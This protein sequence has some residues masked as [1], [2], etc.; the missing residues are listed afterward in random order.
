LEQQKRRE[1]KYNNNTQS[2]PTTAARKKQASGSNNNNNGERKKQKPCN[3]VNKCFK[4]YFLWERPVSVC[5]CGRVCV[6]ETSEI[7]FVSL[8]G[9]KKKSQ[10]MKLP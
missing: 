4:L 10:E 1:K 9:R 6:C 3:C 2:R 7:F 5:D 8:R